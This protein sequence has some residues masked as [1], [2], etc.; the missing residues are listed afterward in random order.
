MSRQA[1]AVGHLSESREGPL[2]QAGSA[3]S[4]PLIPRRSD[5]PRCR[6]LAEIERAIVAAEKWLTFSLDHL[7]RC[8]AAAG[9]ESIV[10]EIM[11]RVTEARLARLRQSRAQMLRASSG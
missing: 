4:Y 1:A 11:V 9:H 7:E 3:P 8:R 2:S 10:A 5:A 6:T